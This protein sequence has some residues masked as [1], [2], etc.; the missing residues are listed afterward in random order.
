M[1]E[2]KSFTARAHPN[3]ALVK[4]WGKADR[5]DNIPAVPS[6]SITLSGLETRTTVRRSP[7]NRDHFRFQGAPNRPME[8]RVFACLDDLRRR[9]G[10]EGA[11]AVESENNFPTAA[12]LAS[13]ASGFAALVIAA[14]ECMGGGLDRAELADVARRA[15]GSA[16]RSLHGGFVELELTPGGPH[17]TR[18]RQLLP[19]GEWPLEIIIAV[20]D[21]A[22]KKI[23]SSRGME[24]SREHSPFYRAWVDSAGDD[25]RIARKAIEERD[26]GALAEIS[27]HSCLK[28]HGLM[29][30]T[31]PGLLYFRA[32]TI[33]CLHRIRQLR[34]EGCSVFF[35]VD[36]GPQVKAVCLPESTPRVRE[37]L[38][39]IPG[40]LR[41]LDSS[42]GVG[43]VL[44]DS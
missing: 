7:D 30:A 4:Y 42:L 41:L 39:E 5:K 8:G 22:P 10:F 14:A 16:A 12:G 11:L 27:E 34:E 25:L 29:L 23:S 3:I 21:D 6:L 19:P 9:T 26:F 32:A 35:T 17:P 2:K 44:V 20:T 40:V 18:C 28:M 43:A 36:A 24:W 38:R 15:S 37:V 1:P 31:P 33:A 13:S